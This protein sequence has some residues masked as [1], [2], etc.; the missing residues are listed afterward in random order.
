MCDLIVR[1]DTITMLNTSA[2]LRRSAEIATYSGRDNDEILIELRGSINK[3][4][5]Y[6]GAVSLFQKSTF[7]A[8]VCEL[9]CED[10][11]I[12]RKYAA[13]LDPSFK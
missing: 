3:I 12:V 13:E 7:N 10:L 6:I 4:N 5:L 1:A 11:A 2:A 9:L 8:R